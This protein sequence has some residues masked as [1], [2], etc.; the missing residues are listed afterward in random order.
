MFSLTHSEEHSE[1]EEVWESG[2]Q[3]GRSSETVLVFLPAKLTQLKGSLSIFRILY[4]NILF[5]C[6]LLG[7]GYNRL[8][9]ILEAPQGMKFGITASSSLPFVSGA[10]SLHN[11]EN[12]LV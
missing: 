10:W 12:I 6:L 7:S 9:N 1:A 8:L 5:C 2:G 3:F 4:V 11:W